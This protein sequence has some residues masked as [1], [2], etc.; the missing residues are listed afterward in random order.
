VLSLAPA[1]AQDDAYTVADVHVDVTAGDALAARDRALAEGQERAYDT[2]MSRLT[3]GKP[4]KLDNT[5]IT[6][7]VAGFEVANEQTSSVRYVA[8]YTFHFKPAAV[9]KLLQGD[10]APAAAPAQPSLPLVVLPVMR[11][12]DTDMLWDDPNPWREIWATRA[13][14][15]AL[16]LLVP[17]GDLADVSAI[18]APKALAGDPAAIKAISARYQNGDVVVVQGAVRTAPRRIDVTAA[19]YAANVSGPPATIVVSTVAKQ[20]ESDADLMARAV[21]D[22]IAQLQQQKSTAQADTA[23]QGAIISVAVKSA[24]LADWVAVRDR[25]RQIPAIRAANL[26]S[27]NGEQAH[28][29]IR[30]VGDQ[31]QLR[32]ALQ[33][34]SLELAGAD[35][36]WLLQRA[37]VQAATPEAAPP[38]NQTA[39]PS[40]VPPPPIVTPPPDAEPPSDPGSDPLRKSDE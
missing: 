37:G 13:G 6:E 9:R 35:P 31:N 17:V 29:D 12:G 18:D 39:P 7:L 14:Q 19:R 16:P 5:D 27:L 2:L 38:P 34:Q 24:S 23:G 26:V 15:N 22:T 3:Q 20:G 10:A 28:V 30:Y 11:I 32:A 40:E 33:Q 21:A 25:L 4:P 1:R 8:D 36:D